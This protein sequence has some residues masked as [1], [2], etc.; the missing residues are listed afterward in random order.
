[1]ASRRKSQGA[2]GDSCAPPSVSC[3]S[4]PLACRRGAN[5]T[6]SFVARG[7]L[8]LAQLHPR[9]TVCVRKHAFRRTTR[10][11]FRL[12]T[13]CADSPAQA[14]GALYPLSDHLV[15]RERKRRV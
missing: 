6:A 9:N 4:L 7:S 11:A 14:F 3:G 5:G 2:E 10:A 12:A 8:P 1:M 13:D 15:T